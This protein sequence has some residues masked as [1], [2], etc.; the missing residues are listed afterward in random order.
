MSWIPYPPGRHVSGYQRRVAA[1]V[2]LL[3][4]GPLLRAV[5]ALA[6]YPRAAGRVAWRTTQALIR[7]HGTEDMGPIALSAVIPAHD[8]DGLLPEQDVQMLRALELDPSQAPG[9]DVLRQ[10]IER[11]REVGPL[12]THVVR[13]EPQ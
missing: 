1:W 6:E 8:L 4:D 10:R 7:A 11:M 5:P 9:P 12:P 2:A 3:V 13:P